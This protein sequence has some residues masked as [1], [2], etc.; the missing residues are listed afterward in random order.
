MSY[1]FVI[2]SKN[3]SPIFE[4]VLNGDA[5]ESGHLNQFIIHAALDCVDE[6]QASTTQWFLRCVDRFND[7]SIFAYITAGLTRF[8]LLAEPTSSTSIKSEDAIR[9]FFLDINECYLRH[10]MNPFYVEG[11]AISSDSFREKV[12]NVARKYLL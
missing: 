4:Y 11:Q 8:M 7:K 10:V 1:S 9:S 2:V 5:S 12:A 3:D 6:A